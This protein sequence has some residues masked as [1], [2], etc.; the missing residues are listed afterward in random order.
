LRLFSPSINKRKKILLLSLLMVLAL[1]PVIINAMDSEAYL[2]YRHPP[3]N[4]WIKEKLSMGFPATIFVNNGPPLNIMW[5][6][7]HRHHNEIQSKLNVSNFQDFANLMFNTSLLRNLY[8]SFYPPSTETV[9]IP[10]DYPYPFHTINFTRHALTDFPLP[11]NNIWNTWVFNS[12]V[13]R[14]YFLAYSG[15]DEESA[16]WI[17]RYN[18]A[19][20]KEDNLLDGLD[21]AIYGEN[22]I[23]IKN[24]VGEQ[25]FD[26]TTNS[27]ILIFGGSD[28]NFLY[29]KGIP[30]NSGGHIPIA[31]PFI[32]P[33]EVAEKYPVETKNVQTFLSL[34]YSGELM[35]MKKEYREKFEDAFI[36]SFPIIY[37]AISDYANSHNVPISKFIATRLPYDSRIINEKLR[38]IPEFPLYIE[39]YLILLGE[40][41]TKPIENQVS[42][43]YAKRLHDYIRDNPDVIYLF[44]YLKFYK[45]FMEKF[46]I[47]ISDIPE[48]KIT[49]NPIQDNFTKLKGGK[50]LE[51]NFNLVTYN[52]KKR[53]VISAFYHRDGGLLN[54]YYYVGDWEYLSI[55]DKDGNIRETWIIGN[56]T[57]PILSIARVSQIVWLKAPPPVQVEK[58]SYEWSKA[59]PSLQVP[60]QTSTISSSLNASA[61]KPETKV[62]FTNTTTTYMNT[63]ITSTSTVYETVIQVI[64]VEKTIQPSENNIF[65]SMQNNF[66]ILVVILIIATSSLTALNFKSKPSHIEIKEVKKMIIYESGKKKREK[67]GE[68]PE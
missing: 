52:D 49:F 8:E 38:N 67:E 24:I 31:K 14:Y 36:N 21:P 10:S 1:S 54:V 28:P 61:P 3:L 15:W 6:L 2:R 66:N 63:T 40:G 64:T 42:Y 56:N 26:P 23:V 18:G 30:W 16:L 35:L 45:P 68:E 32:I 62:S 5:V 51:T 4:D 50:P 7:W 46:N 43:H 55:I 27:I 47:S 22:P 20:E 60:K 11:P 39:S 19:C 65:A 57:A 33:Q 59:T 9:N 37:Q 13:T 48:D 58:L 53:A 29:S 17:L 34:L 41:K 25:I 44:D 12:M